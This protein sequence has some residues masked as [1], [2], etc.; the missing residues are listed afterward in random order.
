MG[1]GRGDD[2]PPAPRLHA[3]HRRLD[4]VE[5]RREV[6]RDDLRP[7]SRPGTPRTGA[8]C[9]MPA[10]LTRMSTEPN[11]SSASATMP[12]ISSGFVMSAGEWTAPHPELALDPGA[13]PLDRRRLAEAVEDDVR[14]LLGQRAGDGEA[15]AAGGAGDEGGFALK[16]HGLSHSSVSGGRPDIGRPSGERHPRRARPRER[17]RPRRRCSGS[18]H[19][20]GRQS[21]G[22][23]R[24]SKRGSENEANGPQRGTMGLNGT[25]LQDNRHRGDEPPPVA[26][27]REPDGRAMARAEAACRASGARLTP[28]R[29]RVL[30]TLQATRGSL[31]AY[32]IADGACRRGRAATCADHHL[33]RARLPDRAGAGAPPGQPQ[34]L[35]RLPARASAGGARRLPD[36]RGLR[37][38]STSGR[39][40]A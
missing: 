30:E 21:R 15:D 14:A 23:G 3:G 1:R 39:R 7:T 35:C 22:G 32:E 37:R 27:R 11:A 33:P 10:L 4:G 29:R 26:E 31:G 25:L 17:L 12:A 19:L 38:A 36:L 8:T 9:W 28:I 34:R 18:V 2:P 40:R 13:L 20:P 16:A 5:G 6:D 24:V